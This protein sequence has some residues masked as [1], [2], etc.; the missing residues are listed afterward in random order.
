MLRT[1]THQDTELREDH[2]AA[3][4]AVTAPATTAPATVN[5]PADRGELFFQRCL[6]CGTPAYRRSFCRACGSMVF[7]RQRSAGDGVVVRRHGQVPGSVQ[8][9]CRWL[10]PMVRAAEERGG[11]PRARGAGLAG[12]GVEAL[13]V[14]PTGPSTVPIEASTPSLDRVCGERESRVSTARIRMVSKSRR[15]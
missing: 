3:A 4:V 6:W 13:V 8:A 11:W 5:A 12:R 1:D 7:Q 10:Q 15:A 14:E 9:P 2:E